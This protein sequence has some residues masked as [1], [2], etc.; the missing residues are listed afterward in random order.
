MPFKVV[1]QDMT[2]EADTAVSV[3]LVKKKRRAP[4]RKEER[5]TA[6]HL[7]LFQTLDSNESGTIT[8]TEVLSHFSDE[9]FLKS[10]GIDKVSQQPHSRLPRTRALSC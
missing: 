8:I 3:T 4:M 1:K 7:A 9:A 2:P 10:V 5:I 6:E